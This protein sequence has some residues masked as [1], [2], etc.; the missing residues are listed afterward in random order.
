M[1]VSWQN[2]EAYKSKACTK[3]WG[4]TELNH[5]KVDLAKIPKTM[6][7]GEK[8]NMLIAEQNAFKHVTIR[9]RASF[10][11]QSFSLLCASC[12]ACASSTMLWG[13]LML[14]DNHCYNG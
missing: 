14:S 2:Q 5:W 11:H 1:R 10:A 12:F 13:L 4:S 8:Q 3:K 9:L 6:S 7:N